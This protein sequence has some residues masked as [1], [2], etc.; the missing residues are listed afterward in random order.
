MTDLFFSE[1]I[2]S[3]TS[4][5]ALEIYNSTGSTVD[6]LAAGYAIEIYS[7]GSTS[8][9]TTIN[10]SGTVAAGKTFVVADKSADAIVLDKGNQTN[11]QLSFN[12]NDAIVLRKAQTVLDAIGQVGFDP[13]TAWI[14]GSISTAD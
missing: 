13:G 1:Y 12:G 2:Q 4:N 10:L 11:T 9:T 7:D 14:F 3:G 6:L 8:V 5:R